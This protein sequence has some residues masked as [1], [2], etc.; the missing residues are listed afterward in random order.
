MKVRD[1]KV[2]FSRVWK[3][4]QNKS[5][6]E[7]DAPKK[8]DDE[9]NGDCGPKEQG[10]GHGGCGNPHPKVRQQALSIWAV[11]EKK[12]ESGTKNKEKKVITPQMALDIFRRMTD[13]D[14]VDIGFNTVQARPEW[15]IL[16]VIPVPPPPVRPSVCMD[17]ASGGLR[18]EDDLTYK[19]GDIIRANSNVLQSL[20]DGV[21]NH[22][23]SDF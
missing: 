17:G 15:M 8:K 13:E 20:A 2:R 7:K 6:C 23:V 12:D 11:A 22:I 4:C 5:S 10:P 3:L 21:P 16:T 9:Y 14:M 1:P 18:N 19:L